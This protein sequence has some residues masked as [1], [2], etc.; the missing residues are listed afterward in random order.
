MSEEIRLGEYQVTH[1]QE[2]CIS[3]RS[4]MTNVTDSITGPMSEAEA[5]AWKPHKSDKFYFKY[6]RVSKFPFRR[7]KK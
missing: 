5:R 3:A 7:H 6:F 1:P 2:F 4:R